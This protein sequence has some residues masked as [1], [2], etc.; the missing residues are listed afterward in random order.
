MVNTFQIL[1][2]TL[3]DGG[4]CNQWN[5]GIENEKRTLQALQEAE[6]DIIECGILSENI[7]YKPGVTRFT[8]VNQLLSFLPAKKENTLYTCLMDFGTY[9]PDHLLPW[10][11]HSPR[12]IR[13]AFHRKDME[14]AIKLCEKIQQKGYLVFVQPMVTMGYSQGELLHLLQLVNT[15]QPYAFYL[16]DSFGM[17]RET[18]LFPLFDLV[19]RHLDKSVR[20][21]FHGHNNL[22]LAFSNALAF[23]QQKTCHSLIVDASMLGMGRGA[24]NLPTELLLS[25]LAAQG[26][27]SYRSEPILEAI[28]Q[29]ILPF[30]SKSPWG[31]SIPQY[32]S[33]IHGVHPNYAGYFG[34]TLQLSPEVMEALFSRMTEDK[35]EHYSQAYADALYKAYQ[36]EQ[37]SGEKKQEISGAFLPS[38]HPSHILR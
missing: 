28:S 23:L 14:E 34:E 4:Y 6:I 26:C 15:L 29:V 8:Q 17:M 38:L 21:G 36:A 30:F 33:A 1:D 9:D 20:L 31:Y 11:G 22:Q 18:H 19:E 7:A 24:G 12:G 16:V 13:V 5:F 27:G 2:C 10:D 37:L 25:H 3:R 32:L 35:K